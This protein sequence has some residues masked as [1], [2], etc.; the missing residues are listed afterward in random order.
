MYR[1]RNHS[2]PPI[3]DYSTYISI[4]SKYRHE[5]W[6]NRTRNRTT[7]QLVSSCR[8]L[9]T[10]GNDMVQVIMSIQRRSQPAASPPPHNSPRIGRYNTK[11]NL[12]EPA[13][14][15][16]KGGDWPSGIAAVGTILGHV[17]DAC[18]MVVR[19]RHPK[20]KHAPVPSCIFPVL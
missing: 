4:A 16:Q 18:P 11:E 9:V 7:A 19:L 5:T 10:I 3:Y 2:A 15:E 1:V 8:Q 12:C 6:S 17:K 13:L 14:P 20:L